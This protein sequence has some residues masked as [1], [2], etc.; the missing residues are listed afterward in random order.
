MSGGREPYPTRMPWN[1][2]DPAV[3]DPAALEAA[4]AAVRGDAPGGPRAGSVGWSEADMPGPRGWRAWIGWPASE[5]TRHLEIAYVALGSNEGD[6]WGF[7]RRALGLMGAIESTEVLAVS[8]VYETQPWGAGD[9]AEAQLPYLNAVAVLGTGLRADQLLPHLQAIEA[10]L[11]RVRGSE[12]YGP[13]TIDLDILLV[14]DEEWDKPELVVPHP[15]MTER[16]F[17]V[18]PL[19]ELDPDITLPDGTPLDRGAATLGPIVAIVGVVPGYEARSPRSRS[20]DSG[21]PVEFGSDFRVSVQ[22]E[23]PAGDGWVAIEETIQGM[24]MGYSG[25]LNLQMHLGVLEDAGIPALLD[26]PPIFASPGVPIY[27]AM[28]RLRLMVPSSYVQAARRALMEA[29]AAGGELRGMANG[30]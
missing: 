21:G 9:D 16:A 19:L 10:E 17:V 20:E 22:R 18:V 8:N 2:P 28:L 12:R 4:E 14:G 29:H 11:G 7:L 25:A 13:R 15:R 26:P 5:E 1:V 3:D 24:M 30:E 6:R 27:A 23:A